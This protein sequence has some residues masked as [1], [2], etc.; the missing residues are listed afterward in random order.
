MSLPWLGNMITLDNEKLDPIKTYL[1]HIDQ[2]RMEKILKILRSAKNESLNKKKVIYKPREYEIIEEIDGNKLKEKIISIIG[3]NF[4]HYCSEKIKLID[5][6]GYDENKFRVNCTIKNNISKIIDFSLGLEKKIE[7]ENLRIEKDIRFNIPGK[8]ETSDK[9]IMEIGET[10]KKVEL[11]IKS[12]N[13]KISFDG[14]IYTPFVLFKTLPKKY[15]KFRIKTDICEFIVNPDMKIDF[16]F[17][18]NFMNNPQNL[19]SLYPIAS[20]IM[21]LY[22]DPEKCMV[23]INYKEKQL[24][25]LKMNEGKIENIDIDEELI[26]LAELIDDFNFIINYFNLS[27]NETIDLDILY[28]NRIAI[29]EMRVFLDVK[30]HGQIGFKFTLFELMEADEDIIIPRIL[31]VRY[32]NKGLIIVGFYQG[33]AQLINE[34]EFLYFS[35]VTPK[36]EHQYE[37]NPDTPFD[38]N[39]EYES[40]LNKYKNEYE[41]IDFRKK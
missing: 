9:A 28:N 6:I 26:M 11:I 2:I 5:T 7:V 24:L 3:P 27:R 38:Y 15:I 18:F 17:H 40:I 10:S 31:G 14:E 23:E 41:V 13:K 20:V 16:S 1:S 22:R 35:T 30:L 25:T 34:K 29:R 12:E 8:I 21:I 36:F 39:S 33:K 19:E 32:N 4:N 37:L